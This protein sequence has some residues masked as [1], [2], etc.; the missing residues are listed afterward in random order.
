M[1][2]EAIRTVEAYAESE[3]GFAET[4]FG[5]GDKNTVDIT[6]ISQ[7]DD[8]YLVSFH[9]T[10]HDGDD[11]IGELGLRQPGRREQHRRRAAGGGNTAD[12]LPS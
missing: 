8:V 7:E 4:I 6:G 12:L 11:L 3:G 9:Y 2:A 1:P 5:G 10:N